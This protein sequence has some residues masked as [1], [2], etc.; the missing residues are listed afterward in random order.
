M[1]QDPQELQALPEAY[2]LILSKAEDISQMTIVPFK[3]NSGLELVERIHG[4][5]PI[6]AAK[7]ATA[8]QKRRSKDCPLCQADEKAH[9]DVWHAYGVKKDVDS[10]VAAAHDAG[11]ADVSAKLVRNHLRN[12]NYNQPA[13]NK[14]LSREEMLKVT[15]S[16]NE[17][18][19]KILLAVYRQRALSTRQIVQLFFEPETSSDESAQKSAY[20]LLHELRFKHLLYPFRVEDRKSPEV[21]YSLGRWAVPFVEEHEGSVSGDA[22]V[23]RRDQVK[24]YQLEH[25]LKAADCFVQLR[26]QL[27]TNRSKDNLVDVD[28]QSM[29]LHLP[30]EH[31]W[32]SRSLS[33]GY[34]TAEGEKT[35]VPDSFAALRFNDGRKRQFQ[36]PFFLE[37]DSGHKTPE[38]SADQLFNYI[39]FSKSGSAGKRFPQLDVEGYRVPVL[40]ITSTATRAQRLAQMV[41]ERA[42]ARGITPE[43]APLILI[44]DAQTADNSAWAPGAWRDVFADGPSTL[45]LAEQLLAGNQELTDKMPIHWR[46]SISIDLAGGVPSATKMPAFLR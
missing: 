24:E 22:A 29:S 3:D 15:D 32:G 42:E 34:K 27:Y 43:E 28:G 37:W 6:P 17:R 5:K 46:L 36:L 21:F 31:W 2:R 19:Q 26:R 40:M 35:V 20:R 16:I 30:S 7:I 9:S 25:D 38:D 18:G 39:P 45:N 41:R 13:P 1:S 23:T 33:M 11:L 12:H 44:T 14:R 10:A 8:A 4:W